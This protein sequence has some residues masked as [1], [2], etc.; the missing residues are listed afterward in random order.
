M[1]SR[2]LATCEGDASVS[3]RV[4]AVQSLPP[5]RHVRARCQSRDCTAHEIRRLQAL[6]ARRKTVGHDLERAL[7]F[8][9]P[10][11]HVLE[12]AQCAIED[13]R[14]LSLAKVDLLRDVRL[15]EDLLGIQAIV[16]AAAHAQV[17]RLVSAAE[18]TRLDRKSVV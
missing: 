4:R 6:A 7:G 3:V 8:G 2:R 18:R 5:P 11:A 12:S 14:R 17:G 1:T 10:E 15:T 16:G 9:L 13:G